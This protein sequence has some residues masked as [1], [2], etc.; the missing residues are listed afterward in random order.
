MN[1]SIAILAIGLFSSTAFAQVSAKMSINGTSNLHD[2]QSRVTKSS[3]KMDLVRTGTNVTDVRSIRVTVLVKGIDSEHDL[4]D[5]KTY[6]AFESAKYPEITFS[7]TDIRL[8]SGTAVMTG[9]LS[10]HGKSQPATLKATYKV[11]DGALQLSGSHS[12]DMTAFG[13]TPPTAVMGT[14]KV[15][16]TV[17]VKYDVSYPL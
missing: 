4:M 17:S 7:A 16:K 1:R 12:I 15:G 11:A 9:T 6:E 10:M 14:I 5:T 3:V 2:W 13:M 8:N